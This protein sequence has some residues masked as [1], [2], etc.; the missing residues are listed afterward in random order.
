MFPKRGIGKLATVEQFRKIREFYERSL[1]R[2]KARALIRY[3]R[4]K[5]WTSERACTEIARLEYLEKKGL[6]TTPEHYEEI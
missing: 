6:P 4:I 1:S 3:Y 2:D 5:G